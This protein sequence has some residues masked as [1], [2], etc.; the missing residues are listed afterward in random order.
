MQ[1]AHLPE[2]RKSPACG[3]LRLRADCNAFENIKRRE[4]RQIERARKRFAE[5]EI[6]EC[7]DCGDNIGYQRLR[8]HPVATRCI[9]CQTQYEKTFGRHVVAQA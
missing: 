7:V 4:L 6:N 1:A 3:R 8:A 5:G 2:K 9:H